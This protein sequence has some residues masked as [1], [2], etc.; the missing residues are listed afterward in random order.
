M[1]GEIECVGGTNALGTFAEFHEQPV[2]TFRNG[3]YISANRSAFSADTI[4]SV[5]VITMAA[6]NFPRTYR[7]DDWVDVKDVCEV[8]ARETNFNTQKLDEFLD[9]M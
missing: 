5:S 2:L 3:S 7:W 1:S 8:F 6:E 4:R 9:G